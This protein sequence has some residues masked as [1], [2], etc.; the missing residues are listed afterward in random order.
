MHPCI[1]LGLCIICTLILHHTLLD[2]SLKA[3]THLKYTLR[4]STLQFLII[5][6]C[7]KISDSWWEIITVTRL[8]SYPEMTFD[9]ELGKLLIHSSR[10]AAQLLFT[11]TFIYV[12]NLAASPAHSL[13][14]VG[15]RQIFWQN[16]FECRF[17][18]VFLHII[19]WA[20]QKN[21]HRLLTTS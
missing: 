13:L 2:V 14:R 20:I 17:W 21:P 8:P 3:R 9:T 7:Y 15:F 12:G 6:L 10:T 5:I 19:T 1:A 4:G 18:R 16:I 11:M